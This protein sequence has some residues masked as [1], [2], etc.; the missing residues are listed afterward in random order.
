MIDYLPQ[1]RKGSTVFTT[2]TRVAAIKLAKSNVIALGE[3]DEKEARKIL[4]TRLLRKDLLKDSTAAHELL[5]ILTFLPLAIVQAVAFI[6]TNNSTLSEY[7]SA[8]RGSDKDAIDLLSKD[9][10]DQGRYRDTKNQWQPHGISRSSRSKSRIRLLQTI[11][12]SWHVPL[13]RT[14][15]ARCCCLEVANWRLWHVR[16]ICLCYRTPTTATRRRHIIPR[17]DV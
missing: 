6:N 11:C 8:Y 2:R 1:S 9:F 4:E 13:A 7:I 15:P 10:K 16:C 3:L 14:F 12:L 17:K 5:G